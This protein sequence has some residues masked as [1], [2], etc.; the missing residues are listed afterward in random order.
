MNL[1]DRISYKGDLKIVL[2]QVCKDYNLGEFYNF[3]L[4]PTGYEDFNL[5]LITSSGKLFV[6]IFNSTRTEKECRR[7]AQIIEKV[8]EAGVSHPK[9]LESKQGKLYSFE[10]IF[11]VVMEYIDGKNFL[12]LNM[13]PNKS[14][15]QFI[16]KQAALIN[17]IDFRPDFVYD[18]WAIPNFLKEYKEKSA[19]LT[20]QDKKLIEPQIGQFKNLK[21]EELPHCFVQ[22]DILAT[23]TMMDKNG[24][25]FIVDFAVSNYY[26]RIIEL[27]VLLSDLFFEMNTSFVVS[28]YQKYIQLTNIEL[29]LLP[30]YISF[31][32]AMHLLRANY[33]KIVNKNN[34]IENNHFL[35]LGRKGL[36]K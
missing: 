36:M 2:R 17:S 14:E 3:E 33:E 29:E 4:N 9:L 10:N 23:N 24:E 19:V 11:L 13:M 32:H 22:G 26:P 16:L 12:E 28:K 20:Y 8:L 27:A 18:S 34:T 25:I 6:K 5:V 30:L 31:A 7:Y 35:E 15:V 21:L 1:Q